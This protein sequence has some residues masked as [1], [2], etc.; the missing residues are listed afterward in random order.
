M[1]TKTIILSVLM[2]FIGLGALA[3]DQNSKNY[4]FTLKG[5]NKTH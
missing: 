4:L 3:Q 5:K 2:I 1:K